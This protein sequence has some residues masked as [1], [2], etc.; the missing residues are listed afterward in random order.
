MSCSVFL[1]GVYMVIIVGIEFFLV[2]VIEKTT[3]LDCE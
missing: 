3:M 2:V 1:I